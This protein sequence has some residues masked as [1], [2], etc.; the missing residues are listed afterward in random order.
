MDV[1]D[2]LTHLVPQK[3]AG[4]SYTEH[5]QMKFIFNA[6]K[7]VILTGNFSIINSYEYKFGLFHRTCVPRVDRVISDSL[8]PLELQICAF[9]SLQ[10]VSCGAYMSANL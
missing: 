1:A 2:K 4:W 5:S 10:T 6:L 7:V 9:S 8:S 3:I